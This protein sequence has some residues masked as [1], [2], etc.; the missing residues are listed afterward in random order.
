MNWRKDNNQLKVEI[1]AKAIDLLR[2]RPDHVTKEQDIEDIL[3]IIR[4]LIYADKKYDRN[5]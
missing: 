4:Y 1:K 2:H 5:S 3:D